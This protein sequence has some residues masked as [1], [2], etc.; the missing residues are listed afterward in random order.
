VL[1]KRKRKTQKSKKPNKTQSTGTR[2]QIKQ[3]KFFGWIFKHALTET[4][5]QSRHFRCGRT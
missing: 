3:L 2:A 5:P 4:Y 1:R